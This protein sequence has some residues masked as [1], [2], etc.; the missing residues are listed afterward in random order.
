MTGDETP[1]PDS[2]ES[3]RQSSLGRQTRLARALLAVA[4]L[5]TLA[6]AWKLGWTYDEASHL[7][8]ARRY[9]FQGKSERASAWYFNS[10]TPITA[11]N[12]ALRRAFRKEVE[13]NSPADRLSARLP[14]AAWLILIFIAS[15]AVARRMAG[16]GAAIGVGLM[17]ALDPNLRAHSGLATSDAAFAAATAVFVFAWLE[18]DRSSRALRAVALGAAFGLAVIAK[19]SALWLIPATLAGTFCAAAMRTSSRPA[20]GRRAK[21]LLIAGVAAY[22]VIVAGFGRGGFGAAQDIPWRSSVF[23]KTATALGPLVDVLPTSLLSGIDTTLAD[24]RA[25]D[26]NV[27]VLGERYNSGVWYYFLVAWLLKTPLP[28]LLAQLAGLILAL[29]CGALKNRQWLFVAGATALL[30][31]Y[32]SFFFH[33]QIGF[34]FVLMCVPLV[35]VLAAYGWGVPLARKSATWAV[36]AVAS[37]AILEVAPYRLDPLAFANSL[38]MQKKDAYR[39]LADSNLDWGQNDAAIRSWRDENLPA[40][41]IDPPHPLKGANIFSV[42]RI[43]PVLDP[44]GQPWLRS[45]L[46]PARQALFTHLVYRL[47]SKSFD[48][49]LQSERRLAPTQ[50]CALPEDLEHL[51]IGDDVRVAVDIQA[52]EFCVRALSGADIRFASDDAEIAVVAAGAGG[53]CSSA[54]WERPGEHWYRLAP[55]WHS[56]CLSAT[57]NLQ[58]VRGDIE[59]EAARRLSASEGRPDDLRRTDPSEYGGTKEVVN[60]SVGHHGG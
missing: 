12:A 13:R 52:G 26:W 57:A 55:G 49:F 42:N 11:P 56:F 36:V 41:P 47:D 34:R 37:L 5:L 43:L 50:P 29:R 4:V 15:R 14:T 58:S 24:E 33:A 27:V 53:G 30:L 23:A 1:E 3:E 35:D 60:L 45:N 20:S 38:V 9:I 32:F 46:E 51:T 59:V 21:G 7:E 54:D 44:R 6:S 40:A 19:L 39:Y 10:K 17:V 2:R 48:R 18:F 16:E 22:L 8:W 28:L 31:G 25:Q